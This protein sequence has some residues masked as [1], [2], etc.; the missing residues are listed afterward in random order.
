MTRSRG[1]RGGRNFGGR[2]IRHGAQRNMR[3]INRRE[4]DGRRSERGRR[5]GSVGGREEVRDAW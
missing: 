5:S 2:D 1:G 3:F 4:S